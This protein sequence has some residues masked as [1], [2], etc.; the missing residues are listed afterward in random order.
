MKLNL[1][2]NSTEALADCPVQ[3]KTILRN[4]HFSEQT[5]PA[6]QVRRKRLGRL[7]NIGLTALGLAIEHV[8]KATV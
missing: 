7:L 6:E 8:G 2:P 4:R 1:T 3:N 5:S